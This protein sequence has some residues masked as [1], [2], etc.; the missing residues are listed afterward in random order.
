[1]FNIYYINY[2]KAYEIAMLIDNKILQ[3]EIKEKTSCFD[4][5]F[6]GDAETPTSKIPFIGNI[7][8]SVNIQGEITGNK[9][10]KVI[11]TINVISTKS[12]IL[13]VIYK[14]AKEVKKINDEHIGKLIKIKNIPLTVVNEDIVIGAKTM[15]SGAIGKIPVEGVGDVDFAT[16]FESIFKDAAYILEGKLPEKRFEKKDK[17]IIKV[18]MQFENELENFYSISDLEIGTLTLVGIYRGKFNKIDIMKKLNRFMESDGSSI[19]ESA[20]YLGVES[21]DEPE[22]GYVHYLDIVAVVQDISF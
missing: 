9:S 13:D 22:G 7:L 20:D 15:L 1:M 19:E 2:Q 17:I 16:L 5:K 4:G 11:D 12:T 6:V 10:K 8:P 3:Q 21:D 14:K 18:P